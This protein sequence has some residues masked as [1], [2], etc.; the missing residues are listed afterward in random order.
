MK[1]LQVKKIQTDEF[2]TFELDEMRFAQLRNGDIHHFETGLA[3]NGNGE[4]ELPL[5]AMRVFQKRY[6]SLTPEQKEEFKN[7]I[8]VA[9]IINE[10]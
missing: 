9:R 2:I 1:I 8:A 6:E 10:L 5:R 4:I 7:K 3:W